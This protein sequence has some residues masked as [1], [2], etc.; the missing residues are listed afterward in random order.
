VITG[1]EN[2]L[3]GM[4][5]GLYDKKENGKYMLDLKGALKRSLINSGLLEANI[6][7]INECTMCSPDK[8]WSH[9]YT[10]G[11]R[12]SQASMIMIP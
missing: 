1:V 4:T 5:Y 8:Y 11:E 6:E 9:R 3:S 10:N 12:G 7:I 2:L